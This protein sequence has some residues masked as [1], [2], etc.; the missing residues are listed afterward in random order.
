MTPKTELLCVRLSPDAMRDVDNLC[1]KMDRGE[2]L[3][4]SNVIRRLI[5]EAAEKHGLRGAGKDGEE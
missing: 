3:N 2:D 5:R 4:R 1:V